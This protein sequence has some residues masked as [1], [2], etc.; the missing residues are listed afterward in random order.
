MSLLVNIRLAVAAS[1]LFASSAHATNYDCE[2]EVPKAL[3]RT[4]LQADLKPINTTDFW[5]GK[6]KFQVAINSGKSDGID[7]ATVTWPN[8]PIN[9]EGEFPAVSI[10]EGVVA[11]GAYSAGPC[12]F[13]EASCLTQFQI[14]DQPDG[15]VKILILPSALWTDRTASTRE[16]FAVVIE[17]N[18]TKY[19]Q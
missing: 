19:K 15:S 12:L 2:V 16:P 4:G 10:A 14:A 1:F 11:F 9:V 17:G 7:I 13:T 8:D 18:C 6:L 5:A 3:Y